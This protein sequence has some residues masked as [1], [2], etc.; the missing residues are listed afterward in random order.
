M[1]AKFSIGAFSSLLVSNGGLAAS[2]LLA[3]AAS[4]FDVGPV[5]GL[6]MFT[7]LL[8]GI[9]RLWG[10]FSLHRMEVELQAA[11]L[12]M[13]P[14]DRAEISY[15]IKNRKAL[16]LIWL[17][18]AQ[19]MPRR[20]CV[21]P[22]EGFS[23]KEKRVEGETGSTLAPVLEKKFAFLMGGQTLRWTSVFRARRRGVY[24]IE[25]LV[26]RSGDGFGL[27]QAEKTFP[28]PGIPTLVVYPELVPVQAGP[29][30]R[31]QWECATGSKGHMEDITVI[32]GVRRYQTNDSW[33]KINWRIAARQQQ[34]MVNLY[35]TVLPKTAHF[36]LD[37]ESYCGLSED[38]SELEG[39]LSILAS[40][41]LR[42]D[43]ASLF[44]GLSLPAS[45]YL[46]A[47]TL[48]AGEGT[49]LSDLLFYL[50]A[51]E[52]L[53]APDLE[54]SPDRQ[55]PLYFPSGFHWGDIRRATLF[56]GRVYYVAYSADRIKKENLSAVSDPS[57]LTL[58]T[59]VET[60]QEEALASGL[61]AFCLDTVK[62]RA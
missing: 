56:S 37:G 24:P 43:E 5:A 58:L 57:R 32:R 1:G 40:L 54:K 29:F 14:G 6:G 55:N 59:S 17:E 33:K 62:R 15:I 21:M 18:L 26:L 35:E 25:E 11:S 49:T 16:P 30:L 28:V 8:G 48:P 51:Y 7:F 31:P 47:V 10:R 3:V 4:V 41:F 19:D 22:E 52:C 45:K 36:I 20:R 44:C 12:R 50:S 42:L 34:L 46:K 53:A 61:P 23:L 27:T 2:F 39:A 38:F 13:Y 60:A 9:S